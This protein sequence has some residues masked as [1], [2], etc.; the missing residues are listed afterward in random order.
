[1]DRVVGACGGDDAPCGATASDGPLWWTRPSTGNNQL[2]KN[3]RTADAA[4]DDELRR[5]IKRTHV[6]AGEGVTTQHRHDYDDIANN[7]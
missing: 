7:Y 4:D 6:A 5:L 2:N 3:L 1:M